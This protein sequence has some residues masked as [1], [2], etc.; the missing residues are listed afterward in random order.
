MPWCRSSGVLVV[1]LALW[2]T[3][4]DI[5][6]KLLDFKATKFVLMAFAH[7][8]DFMPS[9]LLAMLTVTNMHV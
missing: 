1:F 2:S 3:T 8:H 6:V 4:R 7:I 9:A 5:S